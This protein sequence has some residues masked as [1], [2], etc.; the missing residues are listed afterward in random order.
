MIIIP[1]W[2]LLFLEKLLEQTCKETGIVFNLW[3][4]SYNH[5]TNNI[6]VNL[7]LYHFWNLIGFGV[8]IFTL[9]FLGVKY[10]LI[11]GSLLLS[12]ILYNFQ[13]LVKN[14]YYEHLSSEKVTSYA[15]VEEW[16]PFFIKVLNY[17]MNK[18][19][20]EYPD[21][22]NIILSLIK[23][24]KIKSMAKIIRKKNKEI[25]SNEFTQK[26][27][28]IFSICFIV[29]LFL[30]G[31][32]GKIGVLIIFLGTTILGR[33]FYL[34][35]FKNDTD[36]IKII[37]IIITIATCIALCYF[38][39]LIVNCILSF[40]FAAIASFY[41]MFLLGFLCGK[42][43]EL[44]FF[45][46]DLIEYTEISNINIPFSLNYNKWII[47]WAILFFISFCFNLILNDIK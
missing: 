17:R 37:I 45:W 30:F 16:N 47:L 6:L 29:S 22:P 34:M 35:H 9:F 36:I 27:L 1:T 42:K 43:K 41:G 5:L 11:L 39:R 23:L 44:L 10:K 21:N 33:I 38:I 2:Y 32:I 24:N 18:L 25:S 46:V 20:E 26:E 31:F 7:K 8:L 3:E 19:A 15:E 40:I 14:Y 13:N 12:L 4:N 28:I